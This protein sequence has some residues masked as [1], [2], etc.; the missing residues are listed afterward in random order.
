MGNNIS[1]CKIE[2]RPVNICRWG[3]IYKLISKKVLEYM[4]FPVKN[5]AK[6][7]KMYFLAK[8]HKRLNNVPGRPVIFLFWVTS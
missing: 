1:N 5:A 3:Y 6:L 7:A 2:E 8:I 4:L